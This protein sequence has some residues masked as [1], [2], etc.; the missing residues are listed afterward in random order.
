MYYKCII[1]YIGLLTVCDG[2]AGTHPHTRLTCAAAA[3]GAPER[4]SAT[5]NEPRASG[6][7]QEGGGIRRS[8]SAKEREKEDGAKGIGKE[9]GR[10]GEKTDDEE[11]H[12]DQRTLMSGER[13]LPN[14]RGEDNIEAD[15]GLNTAATRE[16]GAQDPATLL[17][18]RG[19][20]RCVG[21]LP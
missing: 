20:T 10:D 3:C 8:A 13:F 16:D 14:R 7:M 9:E 21:K 5:T 4:P 17:E 1:T 15:R 6:A 12:R 2:L 11:T 18:K 19:I